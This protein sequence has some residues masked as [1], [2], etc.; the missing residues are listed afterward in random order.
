[1]STG[2]DRATRL[3]EGQGRLGVRL[4]EPAVHDLDL[5]PAD[6][7]VAAVPD[8]PDSL[9]QALDRAR[10][11]QG[12]SHR[13]LAELCGMKRQ[14]ISRFFGSNDPRLSTVRK[15]AAALGF[16]LGVTLAP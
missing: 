10:E 12:L 3:S 8:P 11:R 4:P 9:I 1:M 2:A 15:V 13:E 5:H 6:P 16:D 7:P 14:Q